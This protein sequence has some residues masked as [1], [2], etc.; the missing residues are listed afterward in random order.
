M[1]AAN[2]NLPLSVLT[3]SQT[4]MHE[5]TRR[6]AGFHPSIW[7]HYFLRYS[8]QPKVTYIYLSLDYTIYFYHNVR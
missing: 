5:V 8:S 1:A 3:T 7:G 2:N 6:S 4:Q